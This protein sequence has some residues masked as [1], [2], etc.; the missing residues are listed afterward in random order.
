MST[1]NEFVDELSTATSGRP[2]PLKS[3]IVKSDGASPP[4]IF[5]EPTGVSRLAEKDIGGGVA[6]LSSI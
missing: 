1:N 2:S 5:P 3:A 4:R 6:A